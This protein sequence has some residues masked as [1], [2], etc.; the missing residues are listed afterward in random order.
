[1]PRLSGEDICA[2][3]LPILEYYP[4]R[5]RGIISERVETCILT[6]QKKL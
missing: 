1:M 4:Q 5:N 6:R 2:A 3:L